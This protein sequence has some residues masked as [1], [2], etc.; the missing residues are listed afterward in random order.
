MPAPKRK[1][2]PVIA[3]MPLIEAIEP[4]ISRFLSELSMPERK[5][6]A[7]RVGTTLNYLSQLPKDPN[8][9][10][11]LATL[12]EKESSR[13]AR[14]KNIEPVSIEQLLVRRTPVQH[15]SDAKT[16]EVHVVMP[17]GTV[18]QR[19]VDKMGR[20]VLVNSKGEVMAVE[21]AKPSLYQLR[22]TRMLED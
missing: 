3:E 20:I 18:M 11:R 7:A 15:V 8:P 22:R 2:P 6:F 13:I 19:R 14:E 21:I 17:N 5:A 1:A 16:G 12:I 10:L 4:P 9:S